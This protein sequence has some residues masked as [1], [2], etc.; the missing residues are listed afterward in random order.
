MA[1][2]S[3][4]NSNSLGNTSLRGFGGLASG[5]DR[6]AIIEQM[7]LGSQ[8]KIENHKASMTKLEWKRDAYRSITDQ[9]LDLQDKYFSYSSSYNLKDP[10]LFGKTKIFTNGPDSSTRFV[11]ASG[12]S[13]LVNTIAI[14]GVKSL[15]TSAITRSG[16]HQSDDKSVTAQLRFDHS[17]YKSNLAG[18]TMEIGS[19]DDKGDWK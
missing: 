5:I 14:A 9:T 19:K 6:D 10:S 13:D 11:T 17:S 3:V 12:S 18:A 8:T 4:S 7:S 15:A 16:V 2:M 1:S